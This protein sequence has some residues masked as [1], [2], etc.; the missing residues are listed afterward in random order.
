MSFKEIEAAIQK[1]VLRTLRVKHTQL[2]SEEEKIGSPTLHV[3]SQRQLTRQALSHGAVGRG[4]AL[5]AITLSGRQAG[6]AA[7]TACE[8]D[9]PK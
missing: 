8:L 3:Q 5:T 6:V 1:A 4:L 9:F 2:C 7:S